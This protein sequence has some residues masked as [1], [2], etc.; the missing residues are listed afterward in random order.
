V[1][2]QTSKQLHRALTVYG[3]SG[4]SKFRVAS[5]PEFLREGTAD[6]SSGGSCHRG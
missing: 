3:W 1:P 6:E 5:N 4:G 2:A